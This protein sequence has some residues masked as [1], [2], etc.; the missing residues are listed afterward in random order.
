MAV[1]RSKG[2]GLGKYDAVDG[3]SPLRLQRGP[4][5]LQHSCEDHMGNASF[6]TATCSGHFFM[7]FDDCV[8]RCLAELEGHSWGIIEFTE[9][10]RDELER[11]MGYEAW[12]SLVWERGGIS[13]LWRW[14]PLASTL[15]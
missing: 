4:Y 5:H 3:D 9:T 11:G 7:L 12:T 1:P 13:K 14:F 10:W 15:E 2:G 6:T 8:G